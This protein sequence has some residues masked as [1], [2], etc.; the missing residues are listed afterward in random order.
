M[1][2]EATKWVPHCDPQSGVNR[3]AVVPSIACDVSLPYRWGRQSH[4]DA[5]P[6]VRCVD[7][8][9]RMFGE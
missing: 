9:L 2:K 3:V 4:R 7:T 6:G 8:G 1:R 5:V